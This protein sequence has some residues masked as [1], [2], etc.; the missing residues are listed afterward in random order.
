MTDLWNV[1]HDKYYITTVVDSKCI[2][3]AVTYDQAV[4]IG[5]KHAAELHLK[6]NSW[7]D[8]PPSWI[9]IMPTDADDYIYLEKMM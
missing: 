3:K 8:R 7:T 5:R 2:A 6:E 1:K 4:N 9:T